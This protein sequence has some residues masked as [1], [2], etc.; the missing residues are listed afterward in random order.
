MA[1]AVGRA[2][3]GAQYSLVA[4]NRRALL[5]LL[6]QHRRGVSTIVDSVDGP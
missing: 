2:R 4:I 3:V 5:D 1:G 6:G